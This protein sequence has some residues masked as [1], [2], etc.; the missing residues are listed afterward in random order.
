M[1]IPDPVRL[2][3]FLPRGYLLTVAIEGPILLAALSPRHGWRTRLHAAWWLT[4]CTYPIVILVLPILIEPSLG[5]WGCTLIAEVF[6]AVAEALLFHAAFGRG[7]TRA[8]HVR[9]SA[10]I[11][12]ANVASFLVGLGWFSN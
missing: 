9:D 1:S 11:M 7:G 8:D 12:L 10:L 2:W 3:Q 6:A 5:W 4:A